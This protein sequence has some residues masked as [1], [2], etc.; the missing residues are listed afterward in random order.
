MNNVFPVRS[1]VP[2][3]KDQYKYM[4]KAIDSEVV[5]VCEGREGKGIFKAAS[6]CQLISK[7]KAEDV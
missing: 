2:T 1:P 3:L 5:S 4:E 7:K 6:I